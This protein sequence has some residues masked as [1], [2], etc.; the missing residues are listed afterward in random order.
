MKKILLVTISL[1]FLNGCSKD[2]IDPYVNQVK[3]EL[4]ILNKVGIKLE[5]SFVTTEVA[6]NVKFELDGNAT[7]KIFDISN[8][9]ISKEQISVKS[10]DNI[11][12]V[13]T[14]A[15]PPSSYRIGLYDSNDNLLGITDFNKIK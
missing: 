1:M 5:S 9:V 10:G 13:Y 2:E 12:K 14:S 11:L 4:Q 3:P 8:K 7:I 6:M 15:L